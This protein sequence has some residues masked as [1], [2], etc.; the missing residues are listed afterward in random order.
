M[1]GASPQGQAQIYTLALFSDRKNPLCLLFGRVQLLSPETNKSPLVNRCPH[2][3][4]WW[5]GSDPEVLL[6]GDLDASWRDRG[7]ACASLESTWI[8]GANFLH[9]VRLQRSRHKFVPY[10]FMPQSMLVVDGYKS[11]RRRRRSKV[12]SCQVSTP[13][14]STNGPRSSHASRATGVR[15][16][17][18][19]CKQFWDVLTLGFESSCALPRPACVLSLITTRQ[20]FNVHL[21]CVLSQSWLWTVRVVSFLWLNSPETF[22][23][24]SPVLNEQLK[25]Y[26][27]QESA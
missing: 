15:R 19:R 3:V 24:G 21:A 27:P 11:K 1:I 4:W 17:D 18:T 9:R 2:C 14:P 26:R 8:R 10:A 12:N 7:M 22:P 13:C 25:V 16:V 6:F 5:T 23:A 20:F